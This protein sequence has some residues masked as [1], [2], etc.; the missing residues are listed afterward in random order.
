MFLNPR[1]KVYMVL[2][3]TITFN[4]FET[5]IAI[6]KLPRPLG[7][8]P[9]NQGDES[10][11]VELES[12]KS[13]PQFIAQDLAVTGYYRFYNEE[14]D[15]LETAWISHSGGHIM[16]DVIHEVLARGTGNIGNS[17]NTSIR[18]SNGNTYPLYNS[19]YHSSDGSDITEEEIQILRDSI[20]IHDKQY[21]GKLYWA[22]TS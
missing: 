2:W 21:W 14:L 10:F 4:I 12:N 1:Y 9:R 7:T 5:A 13:S 18:G 3:L 11:S 6:G 22:L 19:V 16:V 8:R 17:L 20:S 15:Q